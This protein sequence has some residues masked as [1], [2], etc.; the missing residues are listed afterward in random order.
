MNYWRAK[1]EI[2]PWW[3]AV[4]ILRWYSLGTI[5]VVLSSTGS[6][7]VSPRDSPGMGGT[8]KE[9]EFIQTRERIP[10]M[11]GYFSSS[12]QFPKQKDFLASWACCFVHAASAVCVEW[13]FIVIILVT[14]VCCGPPLWNLVEK[15]SCVSVNRELSPKGCSHTILISF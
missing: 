13:T 3:C 6:C 7:G 12:F 1:K 14:W 10:H 5:P 4:P 11:A 9:K 8:A 15:L 2:A